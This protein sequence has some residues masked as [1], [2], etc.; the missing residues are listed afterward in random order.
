MVGAHLKI[1]NRNTR[2]VTNSN[3]TTYPP[4]LTKLFQVIKPLTKRLLNDISVF[5]CLVL[6]YIKLEGYTNRLS[7]WNVKE[8]NFSIRLL[9]HDLMIQA[10]L[11]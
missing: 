11:G 9:A 6:I 1:I 4:V 8:N 7:F 3:L 10:H 2:M 5:S